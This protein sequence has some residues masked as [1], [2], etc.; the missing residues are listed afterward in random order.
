MDRQSL[1]CISAGKEHD[2]STVLWCAER[3]WSTA[4][5]RNKRFLDLLVEVLG[6]DD[7]HRILS[8]YDLVGGWVVVRR[9]S[10]HDANYAPKTSLII[11]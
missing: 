6:R 11:R 4:L 2:N 8:L 5:I 10:M 9:Y 7:R 3:I 1:C